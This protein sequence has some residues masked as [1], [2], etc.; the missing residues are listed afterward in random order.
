VHFDVSSCLCSA[1]TSLLVDS[2]ILLGHLFPHI[3][4]LSISR[5]GNR[6][7]KIITPFLFV[8]TTWFYRKR[9]QAMYIYIYIYIYCTML[10][11]LTTSEH[12]LYNVT[13]LKTPFGLLIPLLQS[14]PT[15]NYIH[16]QLFLTLCHIYTAYNHTR[17]WL[18]SLIT[19]LHWLTSQLSITVSN[20]HTFYIF[21]LWNSRR[22]LTPRIHFLRL[23]LHNC[24]L[25]SH[26]GNWTK[27]ANSF[28]YIAEL[29]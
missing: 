25:H 28:A 24:L 20:Y 13:P 1:D 3:L 27:P 22:D 10:G 6:H 29:C 18:K 15:S 7:T 26:S 4:T 23:L 5:K 11:Y 17:S 14:S 21:T 2:N 19:P 12:Q 8:I 9:C 16:S